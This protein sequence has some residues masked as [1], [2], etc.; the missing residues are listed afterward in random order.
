MTLQVGDGYFAGHNIKTSTLDGIRQSRDV[1]PDCQ[2]ELMSVHVASVFFV[3][4]SPYSSPFSCIAGN[5]D[6]VKVSRGL[7]CSS[8]LSTCRSRCTFDYPLFQRYYNTLHIE[9]IIDISPRVRPLAWSVALSRERRGNPPF[10]PSFC[11]PG[12]P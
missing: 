2:I 8:R 5:K 4:A 3:L 11:A 12:E 7:G 1:R 6:P 10:A 9:Y